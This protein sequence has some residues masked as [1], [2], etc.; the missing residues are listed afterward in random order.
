MKKFLLIFSVSILFFITP[1]QSYAAL[2]SP[3]LSVPKTE[4]NE[5][6]HTFELEG[7][8]YTLTLV[9]EKDKQTAY[10]QHENGEIESVSYNQSKDEL[11]FNG[12][13]A[14]ADLFREMKEVANELGNSKF[15]LDENLSAFSLGENLSTFSV[16]EDPSIQNETLNNYNWKHV[17]YY[18][19][20]FNLTLFTVIAITGLILLLPTGTGA[21]VG[22]VLTVKVIAVMVSAIFSAS[23]Q[24]KYYYTFDTYYQ[25]CWLPKII[26]SLPK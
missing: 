1:S 21:V 9:T 22:A 18:E 4:V 23:E 15:S 10:I 2:S 8:V 20:S 24:S 19:S 16:D 7:E 3:S 6:S 26:Q 13:L 25:A 11:R 12:E 14:D 17:K 5:D